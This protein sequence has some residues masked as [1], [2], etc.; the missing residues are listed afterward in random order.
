[1]HNCRAISR[2]AILSSACARPER[3]TKPTTGLALSGLY[4]VSSS[5]S[6]LLTTWQTNGKSL[7]GVFYWGSILCSVQPQLCSVQAQV[8]FMLCCGCKEHCTLDAINHYLASSETD[9]LDCSGGCWVF[10]A[11][12]ILPH[13][14]LAAP[15]PWKTNTMLYALDAERHTYPIL[16]PTCPELSAAEYQLKNDSGLTSTSGRNTPGHGFPPAGCKLILITSYTF[17]V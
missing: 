9:G 1:M 10:H 5:A 17:P 11:T 4:R 13:C 16:T 12:N 14:V 2:N 6:T 7:V 15:F 3:R 8:V